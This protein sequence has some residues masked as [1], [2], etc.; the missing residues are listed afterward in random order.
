M[1][2]GATTF[3]RTTPRLVEPDT[4]DNLQRQFL[5]N[6]WT[7]EL[8]IVLPTEKRVAA[9]LA[10]HQP[11]ARRDRRPHAADRIPRRL[12]IHGRESGGERRHGGR[13]AGILPGHPGA[14]GVG[15]VGARL[16]LEL[17]RRDGRGQ[18]ADPQRDRDELRASA[19][20][21][22]TTTPTPPSA[23]PT[24]CCR[25]TC[26]AARS[27]ASPSWARRATATP[28]TTSPSP[29]TRSAAP[30]SRCTC[31][32]ASSP[33]TARS[34]CS[35]AAARPRSALAC[36][37]N[38]GAST[39]VTCCT[40]ID[41]NS[42]PCL[43]LD[44]ITARQ[45]I[46]RGGFDTKEKLIRFIHETAE[47]PAGRYWDL[48]LVQNYVYPRATFGEEPMATWLK[49]KRRRADP[50]LPREGHQ[51]GGGRRRS[52]RLLADHGRKVPQDDIGRCLAVSGKPQ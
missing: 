26:R 13:Q 1:S 21:A 39:C 49:A 29:R 4:E 48:Q 10:A 24:A 3:E 28:T 34:A 31:R 11:Q 41:A 9:M 18:R 50:H 15:S 45:F 43:L 35:T 37:R 8:P 52:Q 14:G 16:D 25:R 44:P 17:V 7:D 20:W 22:P 40:G 47:M 51:R 19:R 23:A 2:A 12:G 5:E 33:R 32:R 30:G 6:H 42:T 36:A 38:T 27:P 46:D